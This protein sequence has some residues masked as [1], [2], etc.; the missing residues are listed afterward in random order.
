MQQA[1]IGYLLLVH[2]LGMLVSRSLE[3]ANRRHFV[4]ARRLEQEAAK[5]TE[6]NRTLEIQV[7]DRT[8]ELA[9]ANADLRAEMEQR[10][11]SQQE[12]ERLAEQLQHAQKMEAVGL[13]AGGVAHDFNNIL[14]AIVGNAQEALKGMGADDPHW[15]QLQDI[16][17][18]SDRAAGLTRQLLTFARKQVAKPRVIHLSQ[19]ID[20][21]TRMLRRLIGSGVELQTRSAAG[22]WPVYADPGHI[23]QILLNLAVNARDAMP[24]GGVLTIETDNATIVPDAGRDTTGL[25]PG[26]YAVIRVA[27]TGCGISPDARPRIFE[28]FFTT[29]ELGKGTGLGLSTVFGIA[30]Q[31]NGHVE[32]ESE[33]GEGTAFVVYLPRCEQ[34]QE[35]STLDAEPSGQR[36]GGETILVIEDD[37]MVRRVVVH[38]LEAAGY[39]V[40]VAESSGRARQ[41]VGEVDRPPDLVLSDVVL[42]GASGLDCVE[43]LKQHWPGVR[44]VLMSGHV[45]GAALRR[46]ERE[47][48][49][50]LGKPF[51]GHQVLD[52]VRQALANS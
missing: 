29:K 12:R 32:V 25:P 21:T 20:D 8:A 11:E 22:L 3:L 13:L 48:Y 5:V 38:V 52:A 2:I 39:R 17:V 45:D 33:V 44:V 15:A 9:R 31:S 43:Q 49:P 30:R 26:D 1:S 47:G 42:P 24:E 4:L 34:P 36:G 7:S 27:D 19:V 14:T 37:G 10:L 40:L 28:P 18:A 51:R 50:L 35:E 41:Y 23:Q 16:L 6:S 46:L